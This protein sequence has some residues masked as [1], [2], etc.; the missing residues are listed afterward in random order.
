MADLIRTTLGNGADL[1]LELGEVHEH[2]LIDPG[3]LELA[4]VNLVLNARDAMRSKPFGTLTIALSETDL[5]T[6][7]AKLGGIAPGRYVQIRI[8]DTGVGMTEDVRAR[9]NR[10]LP[11]RTSAKDLDWASAR[12]TG[13]SSNSRA[14]LRWTAALV[15]ARR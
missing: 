10:S 12:P 3:Q 4:L 7:N 13:W 6:P 15:T 1:R 5:A 8:S 14:P 9:S 2:V 11:P